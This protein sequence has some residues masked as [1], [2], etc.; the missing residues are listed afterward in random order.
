M[1][2]P[3][4]FAFQPIVDNSTR[5][6][7]AHEALV[8]GPLGA[9]AASVISRLSRSE[10][11]ETDCEGRCRAIELA[12]RLGMQ[13]SLNLNVTPHGLTSATA[14]EQTLSAARSHGLDPGRLVM[15]VTETE[16]VADGIRFAEAISELRQQ[17][18]RLAIDDFGAGYSGLNLLA[19]FQP[20]ALKLDMNLVRG[21]ESRGPR[22]A[23][24]RAVLAACSDL[25]IDVVAEGIETRD[26]LAWLRDEG[27]TLF[28][29][30]LFARPAFEALPQVTYH[31]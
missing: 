19:D 25:G 13:T 21:I 22:Q 12:A 17:G 20:D 15:E 27:V 23:I 16:V 5:R 11:S 28:Q 18:V 3:L 6:V 4:S 7:V 10:L 24:V 30:Y 29:G 2:P 8:R 9:S 26:E 31:V 1:P 14:M